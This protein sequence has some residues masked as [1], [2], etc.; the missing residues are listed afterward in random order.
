MVNAR[1]YL[2]A[3]IGFSLSLALWLILLPNSVAAFTV[4]EVALLKA[5]DRQK[6]LEEGGRKEG[7]LLWYTTLIVNQALTAPL[8]K[9]GY[10][11]RLR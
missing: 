5:P 6:V 9:T 3:S 8:E 10:L 2:R 1:A 11:P 4:E 7:K